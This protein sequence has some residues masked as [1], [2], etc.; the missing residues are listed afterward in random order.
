MRSWRLFRNRVWGFRWIELSAFVVMIALA[1]SV[2][3]AKVGGGKDAQQ[4]ASV[5]REIGQERQRI[6]LLEADVARAEQP[7]RIER[8]SG[9]VLQLAPATAKH[10]VSAGALGEVAQGRIALPGP[11]AVQP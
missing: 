2:Y 1:L 4:I 9:E 3:L 5:E 7:T 11:P 6:R 10:E 8:L